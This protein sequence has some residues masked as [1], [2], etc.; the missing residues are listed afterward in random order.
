VIRSNILAAGETDET[1]CNS[2]D[3]PYAAA[4]VRPLDFDKFFARPFIGVT[5]T[6]MFLI[7]KLRQ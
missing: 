4:L 5:T 1:V 6:L 7:R 2:A 3:H